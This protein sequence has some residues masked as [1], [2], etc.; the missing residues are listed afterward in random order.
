MVAVPALVLLLKAVTPF[1]LVIL[2]FAAVLEPLNTV[3]EKFEES[4]ALLTMVA[5]AG[6]VIAEE[7]D[8]PCCSR[9]W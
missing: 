9:C 2:A 3:S 8:R 7:G 5:F 4:I 1:K 6:A